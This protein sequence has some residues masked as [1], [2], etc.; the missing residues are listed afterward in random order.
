MFD[1]GWSEMA[2]I[3]VVALIVLGPKEIPNALK[4]AAHWMRTARKMAREFQSGVDQIVREA[5]LDEARKTVTQAGGLNLGKQIEKVVDP[6]GET[7]RALNTDPTKAAS[8]SAAPPQIAAPTPA[9]GPATGPTAGT[10]PAAASSPP[11]SSPAAAPASGSSSAT[12]R[13]PDAPP[14]PAAAGERRA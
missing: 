14:E 9:T 10:A 13:S 1:I 4:T 8:P 6:T 11:P 5:E 12:E 7:K 2:V 3:A